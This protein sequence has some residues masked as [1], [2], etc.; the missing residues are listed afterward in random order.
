MRL[1]IRLA[2]L[3]SIVIPLVLLGS[4]ARAQTGAAGIAGVVKDPSGAV[5]PGVTV[6]ASSPA[7]IERVRAVIT[8]GEGQYKIVSLPSGTY[9]LTFSLPGFN[10]LKRDGIELTA[11]F[12]ATVNADLKV[13][14]LEETVIVSG[15]SPV[16][17]V[18][19]A[20]S[21]NLISRDSLD[22]VPQGK[23]LEAFAALTPGINALGSGQDV[24]G[25]KGETYVQLAIHGTRLADN[26][27]L[28]DG[29]ET[30]DWSGRVFVPSPTSAQE[31]SVETG[32]G[33]AESPADGVY[34]NYIPKDGANTFSGTFG[35][36]GT[37]S[38]LQSAPNLTST[39]VSHGLTQASLPQVKSVYDVNGSF[40]GPIIKNK[41]WFYQADR[42]WGNTTSVVGAYFNAAPLDGY[43]YTPDLGRPALNDFRQEISNIRDT[44]QI[45]E[46]NKLNVSYDYEYRCDCHRSVSSTLTPEA[47][48]IRTYHPKITNVTWTYPATS[49][50]LFEA[51][52]SAQLLAYAPNPQTE[53]PL[54]T[55]PVT[56]L[57]TGLNYR[58][59]IGDTT[60][61]GGYGEKYNFVEN[62]RF[63]A[64]YVTGSQAL[65]LGF[66]WRYGVKRFGEVGSPY[67]YQFRSGVP[68]FVVEYAYPLTFDEHMKAIGG[69]YGQ[70]VWTFKR[71]TLSGGV[72]WDFENA[73][74][75][76]HQEAAGMFVPARSFSQVNCVPC[77]TNFD[78]RVSAA[79]NLF[80]D[81]KT[82]LKASF[83]RYVAEEILNTAHANNPLIASNASATR[84]WNDYSAPASAGYYTPDCDL[85]NPAANGATGPNGPT[86]GA[87]NNANFGI[88][89]ITN[90]YDSSLLNG[91]NRL[92][93]WAS[94]ITLQ[95]EVM[96]GVAANFSFYRTSW[97]NFSLAN[98]LNQP[99]TAWNP[100]C[101]TLPVNASLPG[102][103][104]NPVCG[105]DVN[106]SA[107]GNNSNVLTTL[108]SNFGTQ[109]DVYT[110]IDATI[111]ARIPRGSVQGGLNT[112]HEVTNNCFAANQPGLQPLG[113][114]QTVLN[115]A[116]TTSPPAFC[117]VDPPFWYPQ[118]KLS[119]T[120]NLAWGLQASGLYQ[121]LPGI[122][123]VAS[124]VAT[125]AQVL[126]SLGRNLSEGSSITIANIIA[127]V[128]SS[129]VDLQACKLEYS[130]VSP[131]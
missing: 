59:T 44:W 117:N 32:N 5:L 51:G 11:N 121:S 52:T 15:Q 92:A 130:I 93:T 31:V 122:P 66:Q 99:A 110:G 36:N 43:A 54:S 47:S 55:I 4:P 112:G 68:A 37:D 2:R 96:R 61:S 84:A 88:P 104:G 27:T 98:N 123:I 70:D 118:V 105:Y 124:Y 8:D 24:G 86:C 46:K 67:D 103:G 42:Y 12:T 64:S 9:S 94:S 77:W 40:G 95:H 131:K 63:S 107:F 87:L 49:R 106:P 29:F 114:T 80:G 119:A 81:G 76:A 82:A 19:N 22:A 125:N 115:A 13:G 60:G 90:H 101:V 127:P 23:T 30:N 26:K 56:D 72:R 1:D 120:Y 89:V 34:I 50:L 45:T 85:T 6:E 62:T 78:P 69:I 3:L 17:D 41:M 74:V 97:E 10:A 39:L 16:V 102:G 75:P 7:L 129:R 18:Q 35:A 14:A 111:T 113:Y 108:A 48:A 57:A 79:Y 100:F 71:L 28:L 83:G 128:G 38:R 20:S 65:K 25:S 53:T 109:T 126:P 33:N 58:A 21:R 73:D 91:G 116:G